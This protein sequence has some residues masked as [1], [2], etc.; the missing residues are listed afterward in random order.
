MSLLLPSKLRGEV[1]AREA[2]KIKNFEKILESCYNKIL[3]TNKQSDTCCCVYTCPSVVF[4][5]PLFN[6][7]DCI[8]YIMTKLVEK[9]FEVHLA[10]PNNIF[11]SWKKESNPKNSNRYLQLEYSNMIPENTINKKNNERPRER[12]LFSSNNQQKEKNYR[13]IEDY[14]QTSNN[15]NYNQDDINLFQSKIDELL[16]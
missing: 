1:E 16:N 11:I 10:V 12:K 8:N 3:N 15:I 7:Y 14:I 5:L 13:P 6:M 4:G 2:R 9:G